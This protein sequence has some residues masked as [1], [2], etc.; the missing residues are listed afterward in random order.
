MLIMS[1][2]V[3]PETSLAKNCGI[4]CNR[5]G[6]IIVDRHMKTN[7]ADI[8]AVGDAVEVADFITGN[9]T[10]I[11]LA[12]PANKQGRIAADSAKGLTGRVGRVKEAERLQSVLQ[13]FIDNAAFHYGVFLFGIN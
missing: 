6:S 5:R 13:M 9:P 2:G 4:L 3:R 12:G 1:V 11:P 8:W 10:F 7:V